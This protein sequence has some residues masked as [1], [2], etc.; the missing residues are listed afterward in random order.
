M[1]VLLEYFEELKSGL[2]IAGLWS[3]ALMP[4]EGSSNVTIVTFI[5]C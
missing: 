2:A 4:P 5:Y 3:L 1:N